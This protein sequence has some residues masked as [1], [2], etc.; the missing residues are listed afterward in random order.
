MLDYVIRSGTLLDG[1]GDVGRTADVAIRHGRIVAVGQVNEQAAEEFDAAGLMVT[2]GVVDP[3]THY[4][5]ELFWDPSASPS[6]VHGVTTVIGG[7]AASPWLRSMP[8][9][10]ITSAA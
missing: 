9:T 3:H 6:N 8:R 2:P 4:D 1:T 5:A 10:P 7:I